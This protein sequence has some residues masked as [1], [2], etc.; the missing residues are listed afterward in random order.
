MRRIQEKIKDLV[1]VRPYRSLINYHSNPNETLQA[2]HF[3]SATSELMAKWIDLISDVQDGKGVAKALAG[4]RGVGKSHFLASLGAI[5]SQPDL[6]SK[7]AD[8][9]VATTSQRLKKV[10]YNTATVLRGTDETLLTELK[11]AIAK[12][13]QISVE[14]LPNSAAEI[15]SMVAHSST[16]TPFVILIDT[17]DEREARVARDD[18]AMLGEIAETA[19]NL[20][21]F[22]AIALD[23]D[24]AGADGVNAAISRSFSIDYLDQEHLYRI[25]DAYLFPK[26]RQRSAVLQEIY[27]GLRESIPTFRWSEQKFSSLY[28]LHPIVT[29]IAPFIRLYAPNFALL[30]FAAESVAK[31]S[32]RPANSLITVDEIFDFVEPS[33]RKSPFLTETFVIFDKINSE[34]IGKIAILQ[35]LQAKMILKSLMILSLENNGTSSSE[36]SAAMLIYDENDSQKAVASIENTLLEFRNAFPED[37]LLSNDAGKENRFNL[38][39]GSKNNL[40][41]SLTELA[42]AVDELSVQKIL[43]RTA[44]G[45]F[46]DWT[47]NDE[48]E[49]NDFDSTEST[50]VWRGGNRRGR[51]VWALGKSTEQ[52]NISLENNLLNSENFDWEV[53]VKDSNAN[54]TN[55]LPINPNLPQIVWSPSEF[56]SE[57]LETIKRFSVL[58]TEK[59][60]SESFGDSVQTALHEH[61]ALVKKIWRRIF[62]HDSLL[63]IN[64]VKRGFRDD[65]SDFE[66]LNGMFSILLSPV[67]DSIFPVQPKFSRTLET[68]SVSLIVNQLFSE[69]NLYSEEVNQLAKDFALPLGLVTLDGDK[70]AL[71]QPEIIAELPWSLEIKSFLALNETISIEKVYKTLKSPPFG[72][73][74]EAQ[75]L[76]LAAFVANRELEFVTIS[77][78]RIDKRSLDLNII[79]DDIV[80][81]AKPLVIKQNT[82][83][84]VSWAKLL[85]GNDNIISIETSST[86]IRESLSAWLKNW[87]EIRLWERFENLPENILN[88]KMWLKCSRVCSALKPFSIIIEELLSTQTTLDECIN[89][90]AES[91]GHSMADFITTS[92]DFAELDNFVL[93]ASK[94][95]EISKY[96]AMSEITEDTKIE[97]LRA[98]LNDVVENLNFNAPLAIENNWNEFRK[99]Y[100]DFYAKNHDSVMKSHQLSEDIEQLLQSDQW[101]EFSNLEKLTVF[102]TVDK[103]TLQNLQDQ[104]STLGCNH[105][106][107]DLIEQRPFCVCSFLINDKE[108]WENLPNKIIKIMADSHQ[109]YSEILHRLRPALIPFLTEFCSKETEDDFV[110]SATDLATKLK[111]DREI[112]TL[113]NTD[114]R[115]IEL[116]LKSLPASTLFNVN[117]PEINGIKTRETLRVSY[118]SWISTLPGEPILLKI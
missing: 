54:I 76:V 108:T 106:N 33:L 75:N 48:A 53:I 84:L 35:R 72:L 73:T 78:N 110:K 89:K 36:I 28:P 98:K 105:G 43:R 111:E 1:D 70:Y 81:I 118:N 7:I 31:N 30:G 74:K 40:N 102:Q 61:S 21:V 116:A 62:L 25:V 104:I 112:P 85:T 13:L 42:V 67:F 93:G 96:L 14:T 115:V 20:N 90:I 34:V 114:L 2:Y 107:P 38:R 50:I 63:S 87:S 29:E 18:G 80:G 26:Q 101:W 22:V 11:T 5:V 99:T 117:Q 77:G 94:Y 19:K 82:V 44:R 55:G 100:A 57:E 49:T 51:I 95:D 17:L 8:Q 46:S 41:D 52:L 60:L 92:N 15:I 91:F 69:K 24:I 71:E 47:I 37:V 12:T 59:G 88:A 16:D 10:R 56:L 66:S 65:N 45:V 103:N 113:N 32:G 68:R 39:I 58:Q 6:R 3:T 79:W 27:V 4:Y 109:T 83:E 86:E 9:H 23:D 97:E 64:D